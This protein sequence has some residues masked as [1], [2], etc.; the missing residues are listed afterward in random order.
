MTR[1]TKYVALDGHQATTL[2][3]VRAETGQVLARTIVLTEARAVTEFF[4][5][6]RGAV[7]VAFEEGTQ[8]VTW[9]RRRGVP[10]SPASRIRWATRLRLTRS[11]AC[12]GETRRCGPQ[13]EVSSSCRVFGG[14]R[15]EAQVGVH[16]IGA[17]SSRRTVPTVLPVPDI[18]TKGG[19]DRSRGKH[20][21][22]GGTGV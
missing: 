5:G 14:R 18:P 13:A 2:A 21:R 12:G 19:L 16:Q 3:S 17:T 20:R 11:P 6:V 10:T 22:G 7:P 9:K 4:R 15:L 1:A 8:A